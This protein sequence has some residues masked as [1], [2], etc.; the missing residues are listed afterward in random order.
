MKE[1]NIF[2]IPVAVKGEGVIGA[3]DKFVKQANLIFQKHRTASNLPM[4]L[5]PIVT[6]QQ[7]IDELEAIAQALVG[8]LDTGKR[9][10]RERQSEIFGNEGEQS[11]AANT[12]PPGFAALTQAAKELFLPEASDEDFTNIAAKGYVETAGI[13]EKE[14]N[15]DYFVTLDNTELLELNR[16]METVCLTIGG[17]NDEKVISESIRQMIES[18]TGDKLTTDDLKD[19]W[20]DRNSIPLVTQT[21]LG[22]GMKR[23]LSDY[24]DTDKLSKYKKAFC[25]GYELTR[26]MKAKKKLPNPY[27]GASLVW[28]G[29]FYESEGAVYH[30]WLYKD[31]FER[32]YYYLPLTYLPGWES[33]SP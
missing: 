25:R 30:N 31:F 5:E 11:L 17:S 33:N 21:L 20:K 32:G 7:N 18:L 27:D 29:D 24:S 4:A 12:L 28:T 10:E 6:Y 8:S 22:D 1:N 2:Y 9:A 14:S 15:W 26:L 19:Y 16:S 23:F 13:G 3:S